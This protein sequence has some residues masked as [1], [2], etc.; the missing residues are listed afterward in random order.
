MSQRV[1]GSNCACCK[2]YPS[3]QIACA[4]GALLVRA[5]REVKSVQEHKRPV[6]SGVPF[7]AHHSFVTVPESCAV[8]RREIRKLAFAHVLE[9]DIDLPCGVYV[10]VFPMRMCMRW[11]C[12]L[13]RPL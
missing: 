2:Q 12:T 5:E 13:A 10:R 6:D 4:V 1:V 11:H 8:G 3:V 9:E 7:L